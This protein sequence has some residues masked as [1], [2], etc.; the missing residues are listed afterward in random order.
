MGGN[1]S[2]SNNKIKLPNESVQRIRKR[3]GSLTSVLD[4]NEK[5]EI[6]KNLASVLRV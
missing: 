4:E 6:G 2:K 5:K 1:D 3:R